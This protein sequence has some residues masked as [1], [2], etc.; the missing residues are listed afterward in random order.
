MQQAGPLAVSDPSGGWVQGKGTVSSP[1]GA[2]ASDPAATG[3]VRFSFAARYRRASALPSD[4]TE[5]L[6]SAGNLHFQSTSYRWLVA[7]GSRA[8][9]QGT[10]TVN[11][12]ETY[13][14]LLSLVDGQR[15]GSRVDLMRIQ[16]WQQ[17]TGNVVYDTQP[18]APVDAAP[19]IAL[20]TGRMAIHKYDP[21][22]GASTRQDVAV[23]D[24]MP[25]PLPLD[26]TRTPM[27]ERTDRED[28]GT[29]GQAG[30]AGGCAG[31]NVVV[32]SVRAMTDVSD[33]LRALMQYPMGD[34]ANEELLKLGEAA[35]LPL[36]AALQDPEMHVRRWAAFGLG[37]LGDTRAVEPLLAALQDPEWEVRRK[38][39]AALFRFRDQRA[40]RPLMA[41]LADPNPN[42]RAAAV[43]ALGALAAV[44]AIPALTSMLT[45]SSQFVR[46]RAAN[47]LGSIGEPAL[48][49]LLDFL[50]NAPAEAIPAAAEA[51][52]AIGDAR[53]GDQLIK[54]LAHPDR[55]VRLQ[56][57]RAL[58]QLQDKRA[59]RPLI[60]FLNDPDPHMRATCAEA[61][62]ALNARSAVPVLIQA[63]QDGEPDVRANAAEALAR[64]ATNA[65]WRPYWRCL[66]IRTL[67]QST[68]GRCRSA[69]CSRLVPL[70]TAEH[71]NH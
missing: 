58:G 2:L 9:Y 31:S 57:A 25:T 51:L 71:L 28:M 55:T 37:R 12:A 61:L 36:I 39:A 64:S 66:R 5:I 67:R 59:A 44:E 35:V 29:T 18:G 13:G 46:T 54:L 11:G 15:S 38:S 65:P 24:W 60:P 20:T 56:A 30:G 17:G 68:I 63:L 4:K 22:R 52:E 47:A 26:D 1:A 33:R 19:T 16:I 45:D 32:R 49:P 53:A 62:G 41:L 70:A 27:N 69:L 50:V 6:F 42:V 3:L 23:W 8:Q 21:A 7:S 48:L 34:E 14:F 40:V 10:G 43:W